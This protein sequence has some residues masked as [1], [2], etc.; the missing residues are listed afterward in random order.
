M[1]PGSVL[2]GG[3]GSGVPD[4]EYARMKR[5]ELDQWARGAICGFIAGVLFVVGLAWVL[6]GPI[7]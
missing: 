3:A 2:N 6:A 1:K 4:M 7:K 5:M